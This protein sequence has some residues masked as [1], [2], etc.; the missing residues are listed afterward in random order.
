MVDIFQKQKEKKRKTQETGHAQSSLI[1]TPS[2]DTLNGSKKVRQ[3]GSRGMI[4]QTSIS[5][6]THTSVID[7]RKQRMQKRTKTEQLQKRTQIQQI[8]IHNQ[9]N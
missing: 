9:E 7:R 6:T 4:N 5:K 1:K 8:S 3:V 2:H